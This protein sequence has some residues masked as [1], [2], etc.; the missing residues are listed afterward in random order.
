MDPRLQ[1]N[2]S[3]KK[4]LRE[5]LL[6]NE[7]IKETSASGHAAHIRFPFMGLT[8]IAAIRDA[9]S[10]YSINVLESDESMSDQYPTYVLEIEDVNIAK[11]ILGKPINLKKGSWMYWVNNGQRLR[12]SQTGSIFKSKELSPTHLNKQTLTEKELTKDSL[13]SAVSSSLERKYSPK[14]ANELIRL[15]GACDTRESRI[16]ITLDLTPTDIATTAKDFGEV[17]SAMWIMNRG[18]SSITFPAT[19]VQPLVDFIAH[20]MNDKSAKISVKSGQGSKVTIQN[21]I[22]SVQ[23]EATDNIDDYRNEPA[24]FVFDIVNKYPMKEGMLELHKK[25]KT[26]SIEKLK[27]ITGAA[28]IDAITLQSLQSWAKNIPAKSLKVILEPFFE[29]NKYG[30]LREETWKDVDRDKLKAI[31]AP[32]GAS[33]MRI[34]NEDPEL[35]RSL[36]KLANKMKVKQLDVKLLKKSVVFQIRDFADIQFKFSWAGYVSG[37]KLGFKAE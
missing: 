10:A 3:L 26:P 16:D 19:E 17:I 31:I 22:N 11:K 4:Y 20:G 29:V 2:I 7:K 15:L 18:Y 5:T 8:T 35:K 14:V 24:F 23:E 33:I 36:N 32:L 30:V 27:E 13:M 6:K 34:L 37:N 21:I 25:L 12:A 9:M 28:S 1:D